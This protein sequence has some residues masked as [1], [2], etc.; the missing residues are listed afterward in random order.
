ME[1]PSVSED[2][3]NITGSVPQM[4]QATMERFRNNFIRDKIIKVSGQMESV[5]IA[6]YPYEAVEEAVVN[7]FYHRDYMS[8]E[9]VTIEIEPDCINIISFPGIDRS[10]SQKTIMEGRRFISRYY[11]N[12]CLGEFLKELDLSEGHSTGIS[13]I[14]DELE[15]NGSP[16]AEFFTDEDRR[17][18]RIRIPI[19]P[20]F[21][22]DNDT[23]AEVTKKATKKSNGK[24]TKTIRRDKKADVRW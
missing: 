18:T 10:I 19:H 22:T 14:Q 24:N 15:K 16:R 13:T 2:F 12:R 8:C 11:R 9:P 21:L 7:A 4:I 6:N 23:D 3:P 20:A 1:N 17:A 5:R